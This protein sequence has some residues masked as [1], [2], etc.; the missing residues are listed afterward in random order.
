[1]SQAVHGRG[2]VAAKASILIAR[3]LRKVNNLMQVLRS[4]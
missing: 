2:T 1:M 3:S 4:L